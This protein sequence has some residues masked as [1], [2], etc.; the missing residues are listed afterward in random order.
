MPLF[1]VGDGELVPFRRVQ[2]GPELYEEEIEALLWTDLE[3]FTG[4][5]LFPIARQPRIADGLRPDIVALDAEGRVVVIEVKR[6]IDLK[7]LAQCLEYAGWARSTSLDEIAANY[8]GGSEEFFPA[9]MEFTS[10]TSPRL[11]QRPPRV[12]LVARDF[13]SRTDGALSFL[14][15]SD[16]PI[17][18]LRVTVYTDQEGRRFVDVEADH[19]PEI[20]V[21]EAASKRAPTQYKVDGRRIEVSDLL[22]ANLIHEGQRLTW[23]RPRLGTTYEATILDTGQIQL[24]DGRT[25][26]TLSRAAI[27]AADVPAYDGWEAWHLSDGRSM[28]QVRDTFITSNEDTD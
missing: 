11:I 20:E 8:H 24:N 6:D 4:E 13:D 1:E 27:T 10:T 15:D 16:L 17:S 22:D 19:E 25:F 14:T 9:W 21:P 7:Q 18:V 3:A 26:A 28:K 2:A 23:T 5:A 12:V